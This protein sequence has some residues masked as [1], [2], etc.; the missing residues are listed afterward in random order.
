MNCQVRLNHALLPVLRATLATLGDLPSRDLDDLACRLGM[1]P[2]QVQETV[3]AAI[4]ATDPVSANADP[5]D[6]A[7]SPPPLFAMMAPNDP[8][9]V[10][11]MRQNRNVARAARRSATR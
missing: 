4:P 6:H 2:A 10:P 8:S 11:R 1:T 5:T 3:A 7:P 9:H